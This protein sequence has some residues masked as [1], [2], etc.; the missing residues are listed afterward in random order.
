VSVNADR[1]RTIAGVC[2]VL[3]VFA[4]V[5]TAAV[6]GLAAVPKDLESEPSGNWGYALIPFAAAVGLGALAI[7]LWRD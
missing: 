7:R 2:A 1:R 6:I 3:A 4:A 5:A